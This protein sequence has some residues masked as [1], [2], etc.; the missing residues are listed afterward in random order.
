MLNM[1]DIP[2]FCCIFHILS[3]LYKPLYAMSNKYDQLFINNRTSHCKPT[4]LLSLLLLFDG[5]W[6]RGSNIPY[7]VIKVSHYFSHIFIFYEKYAVEFPWF[8]PVN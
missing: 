8:I 6:K 4:F 3:L 5:R 1:Y 2:R 7:F